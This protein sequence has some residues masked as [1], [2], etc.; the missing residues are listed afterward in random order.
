[1]GIRETERLHKNGRIIPVAV[2]FSP[3]K[4]ASEEIIGASS[5][6]RYISK[7]KQAE[8][9]RQQLLERLATAAKRFRT[10][11]PSGTADELLP[12][13][14]AT[15]DFARFSRGVFPKLRNTQYAGLCSE[16]WQVFDKIEEAHDYARDRLAKQ[17]VGEYKVYDAHQQLVETLWPGRLRENLK[18]AGRGNDHKPW[19]KFWK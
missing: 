17:G 14:D 12:P 13:G 2:T 9:E 11:G 4:N 6:A 16:G 8:F 18:N 10:A 1:M 3:I 7:Q 19:W 5:I 15:S